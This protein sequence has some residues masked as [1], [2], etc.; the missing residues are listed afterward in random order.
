MT[1]FPYWILSFVLISGFGLSPA[2]SAPENSHPPDIERAKELKDYIRREKP[3]FEIRETQRKDALEDL[4]KLNADQNH[5]RQ[6]IGDILSSQQ[7]MNMAL[8]NL[9]VEVQ[10]QR[11][12]ENIQ[13][14]RLILLLKIVYKIRKDGIIR[15]AANGD[16]LSQLTGRV[17]ILYRTLRSHSTLT[18]ELGERAARLAE[19][20]IKLASAREES[21]RLLGE[22][23]EQESLLGDYLQKKKKVLGSINLKQN[24]F[25]E[26][27]KEYKQISHHL[28]TLFDNFEAVR[29]PAPSPQHAALFPS[30]GSLPLPIELGKLVKPFGRYVHERFHTVTYQKGI[31]IEAEHNTPVTAIL[32]GVVEYDGWVKGLGN[33]MILHHGNGFYT[34]SAHLY[35]TIPQRGAKVNQGDTIGFVGDT[36]NNE[37]PSLYFEVREKGQAVDPVSY[38]APKALT[39]LNRTSPKGSEP[40]FINF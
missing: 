21:H 30:R 23:S 25:Q 36:G 35:K 18:Q 17:R 38:F 3:K 14:Q 31:E 34:L 12:M 20:K 8:D 37:K 2:L 19:S 40:L 32:G 28:T 1:S 26:A 39:A 24:L 13:K 22:L 27:L 5:V 4:D 33:V 9:A 10:K 11:Q 6:R 7:E 29:T 15:F 16:N